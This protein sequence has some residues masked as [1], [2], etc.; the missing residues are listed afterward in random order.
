MVIDIK[1]ERCPEFGGIHN[2]SLQ[3]IPTEGLQVRIQELL[4]PYQN[5]EV[6]SKDSLFTY[7]GIEKLQIASLFNKRKIAEI[8]HNHK[9][10]SDEFNKENGMEPQPLQEY[11]NIVEDNLAHIFFHSLVQLSSGNYL[12]FEGDSLPYKVVFDK[13]EKGF[14]IV[15]GDITSNCGFGVGT[16][17]F[18]QICNSY[19]ATEIGPFPRKIL[20]VKPL[21]DVG[22]QP[23]PPSKLIPSELK[24][25]NEQGTVIVFEGHLTYIDMKMQDRIFLYED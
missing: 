12:P 8:A 2:F 10:K 4:R 17:F 1:N 19:D 11:I 9:L 16:S 22:I 5:I 18:Y 20:E 23:L 21:F 7:L 3:G 25:L 24:K 15:D 6:T 14:A 13:D